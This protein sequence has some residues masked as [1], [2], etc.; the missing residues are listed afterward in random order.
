MA[1]EQ[2]LKKFTSETAKE[3]Q[4][5]SVESRYRNKIK[6]GLIADAILEELSADDLREIARGM[7]DRAKENS[8]DLVAMRDTIGEKPKT[9][10]DAT[11]KNEDMD[12]MDAI[13][14]E[15]GMIDE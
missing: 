11:V 7:I 3:N 2:N 5:K 1:N 13:L 8:G 6:K 10:V 9:E 12:K 15:L 4:P 14:G